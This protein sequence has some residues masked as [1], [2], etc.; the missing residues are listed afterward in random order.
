MGKCSAELLTGW[1][2]AQVCANKSNSFKM[3]VPNT[4][5]PAE[6]WAF[7]SHV[8]LT[9][10][11]AKRQSQESRECARV[12]KKCAAKA[13]GM[14]GKAVEKWRRV[15]HKGKG[16]LF[17]WL[18]ATNQW[19]NMAPTLGHVGKQT[20]SEMDI[21]QFLQILLPSLHVLFRE[22]MQISLEKFLVFFL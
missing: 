21:G 1:H 3:R 10:L 9:A 12:D 18:P 14:P 22:I 6:S 19:A 16:I 8:A 11:R 17:A 7:S 2:N 15:R 20:C 4:G 5:Q 13:H